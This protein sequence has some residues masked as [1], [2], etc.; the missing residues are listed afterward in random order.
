M[1]AAKVWWFIQMF[2]VVAVLLIG[3]DHLSEEVVRMHACTLLCSCAL[4]P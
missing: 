1:V 3:E 4:L 2:S